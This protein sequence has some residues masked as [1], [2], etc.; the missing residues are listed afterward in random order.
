M[1]LD[2]GDTEHDYPPRVVSDVGQEIRHDGESLDHRTNIR[3]RKECE[4]EE[5][6]RKEG[7]M[8]KGDKG[9]REISCGTAG[10]MDDKTRQDVDDDDG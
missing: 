8:K 5:T 6:V 4:N 7:N 1:E 3:N 9:Q 10:R 2:L